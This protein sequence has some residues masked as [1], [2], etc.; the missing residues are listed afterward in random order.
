MNK[1]YEKLT[2]IRNDYIK[3]ICSFLVKTKPR[4]ITIENL[5]NQQILINGNHN[6]AE[7]WAK[8]KFGYFKDFLI[9][10]CK[11]KGIELRIANKF[12]PSSKTCCKCGYVKRD[13]TL[14]DRTY[15]C[16]KCGLTIDRDIN[17]AINLFK[18]EDYNLAY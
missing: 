11:N 16:P 2:F 13:L 6:L 7:K 18:L 8:C 10:K 9:W 5:S 17:A 14:K 3:K 15:K 1:L 12:Y 4:Y